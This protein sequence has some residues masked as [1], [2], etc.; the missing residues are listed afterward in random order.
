M[1]VH[2]LQRMLASVREWLDKDGAISD[3]RAVGFTR[4]RED[5]SLVLQTF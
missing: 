2:P 5:E 4:I 1:L 3:I